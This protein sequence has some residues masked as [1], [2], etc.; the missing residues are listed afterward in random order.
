MER[1]AP[2]PLSEDALPE[3]L[4]RFVGAAA[5]G[6]AK[7]MAARGL[8]PVKGADLITVLLQLGAQED[9]AIADAAR[10]TFEGLPP[11]VLLAACE[12]ALPPAI[13]DH[14]AERYPANEELL[15]RIV[16]ND[17]TADATIGLIARR[18]TEHIAEVIATNQQ[19]VLGAPTIIEALYK[20]KN[21]RM[22]TV[23]RLVELAARH[24]IELEG[25]PAF[26]L[27]VEA[28][29]GQLIPEPTDEPLP[30]DAAFT[31]AL[32]EDSSDTDVVDSSEDGEGAEV[33]D[34]FKPLAFRI[35]EMSTSEKIR[36]SV[37]GDAAARALLVRDPKKAVYLATIQS[38]SMTDSEAS[39]IAHSKDVSVDVLRYI[40]N[41]KEWLKAYDI[42]M[43]LVF[44]PKSPLDCSMKFLGHLRPN[45][46]KMLSQSRGVT[47]QLKALARTRLD[48][49]DKKKS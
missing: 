44:N 24:G 23:D 30:S 18:C 6:P 9:S 31:E 2:L 8:V 41:R 39:A 47:A 7:M 10:G 28:I 34:R 25:I 33:K 45:D 36:F 12:G 46:L 27:H 38:P 35:R 20:N 1:P 29:A 11:A 21:T 32:S 37:V 40:G 13:L 22:S 49:M 15:E 14:L 16:M 19:R 17:V 43:A 4:R 42:K 48:Q 3:A 26:K 5:P